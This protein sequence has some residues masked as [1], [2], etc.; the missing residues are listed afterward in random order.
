LAND[1]VFAAY[2]RKLTREAYRRNPELF[3]R[4]VRI[5]KGVKAQATPQWADMDLIAAFYRDAAV[6]T[7]EFGMAMHVDHIVPL[8][9]KHVC[10]LHVDYNLRIVEARENMSKGNRLVPELMEAV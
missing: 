2:R 7:E 6:L 9:G 8:L 10:G 1:P 5:R 3:I 4:H